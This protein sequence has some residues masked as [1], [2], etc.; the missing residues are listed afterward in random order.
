[1]SVRC[2]TAY[3]DLFQIKRVS[4]KTNK[5]NWLLLAGYLVC[6]ILLALIHEP[7][8]D[9]LHAW[10]MARDMSF[11]ELW[12]AMKV[13]GHFCLWFWILMPFAKAGLGVYWL[14]IISIAFMLVAAWILVFKTDFSLI[15]KA[16]ILLSFPMVYQFPV[17]SRCYVLIPPILFGIALCYKNL[18][19]NKWLFAVLVGMLAHT[20]VYMEGMVLAL[21]LVYFNE[22]IL[23][24]YKEKLLR[25][26]D[27]GPLVVIIAFV[28]LAFIQVVRNPFSQVYYILG[29][30]HIANDVKGLVPT[31]SYLL[32]GYSILPSGLFD[33][34]FKE[35]LAYSLAFIPMI[36][37]TIAIFSS[38]EWKGRFIATVSIGWQV[39]FSFL[40]YSFGQHRTY[41]PFFI[42]LTI[43]IMLEMKGKK[44]NEMIVCLCIL[45]SI[46]GYSY[47]VRKDI[48]MTY[49]SFKPL[50]N[51]LETKIPTYE[52]I[53]LIDIGGECVSAYIDNPERVF[54]PTPLDSIKTDSFY[55]ISN[56]QEFNGYEV[57]YLYDGSDCFKDKFSLLKFQKLDLSTTAAE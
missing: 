44:I 17:I 46:S 19:K 29:D 22:T 30:T 47:Q 55:A 31:V 15:A 2:W 48:S 11:S 5:R 10:V 52:P 34:G 7:W 33:S 20:H 56:Q 43:F 27:F 42:F 1:M 45:A 36:V 26:A 49:S 9:E 16:A 41:L 40:I 37:L 51:E 24:K 23:P 32:K 6:V 4:L 54:I 50:A 35:I 18:G 3:L 8:L 38:F 12:S 21:F 53:Y 13:E 57:T 28:I 14:Q 25:I 39:L